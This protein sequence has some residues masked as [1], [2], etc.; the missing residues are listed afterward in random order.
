M[1]PLTK[2]DLTQINESLKAIKDVKL[3]IERAKASGIDVGEQ[4]QQLKTSEERLQ[5]IKTGFFPTGRA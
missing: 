2:E 5:A 4:E 1:H 3:I